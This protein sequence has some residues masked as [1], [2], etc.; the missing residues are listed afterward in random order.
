M[1]LASI[2]LVVPVAQQVN[3]NICGQLLGW[4]PNVFSV[5]LGDVAGTPTH[6]A[7]HGWFS[8]AEIKAIVQAVKNNTA[9]PLTGRPSDYGITPAQALT[10]LKAIQIDGALSR[11]GECFDHFAA[12]VQAM[13]KK[14]LAKDQSGK[15]VAVVI[16]PADAQTVTARTSEYVAAA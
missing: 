3:A 16:A 13:T 7:A 12:A 11:P 8:V 2:V 6:Y 5:A 15:D 4:G 14:L 1:T 9:P 10:A